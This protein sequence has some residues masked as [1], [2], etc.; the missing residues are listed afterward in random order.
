MEQVLGNSRA[1]IWQSV[2]P[3]PPAFSRLLDAY[4]G[5]GRA[6]TVPDQPAPKWGRLAAL[7]LGPSG[8]APGVDGEPYE[9]Y[10]PGAR[11]VACLLAQAWHAA[12]RD[13]AKL[14][15]V[16]GPS[17]DLLVWILKIPD[18]ERPNDLRPL[19]LP[20]CFRRLFGASLADL[21]G[22]IVEP[23]LSLHLRLRRNTQLA[24][25][26]LELDNLQP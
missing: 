20:T 14:E 23:Q 26:D 8:S 25:V 2:P 22:P 11:F 10:H 7:I 21:L 5:Q 15:R 16:L 13:P 4:F 6:A 19:Q 24:E 18:A 12:Q 9:A 17:V 3:L 1:G